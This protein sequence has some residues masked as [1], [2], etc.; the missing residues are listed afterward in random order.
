MSKDISNQTVFILAVLAILISILG[1][2]T[3][4]FETSNYL[5]GES[6]KESTSSGV[7]RLDIKAPPEADSSS[8]SVKL[9]IVDS[10][11]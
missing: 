10:T 7:I 8:G 11:S 6:P 4:F 9:D 2:A 1:V 3:I 5:S